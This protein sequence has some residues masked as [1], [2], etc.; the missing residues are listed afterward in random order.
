MT[1]S[2]ASRLS[3]AMYSQISSR[4][5]GHPG[6]SGNRSC[7]AGAAVLTFLPHPGKGI[8]AVNRCDSAVLH[9]IIAA[10]DHF[11]HLGQ[12]FKIS[13]Q[14]VLHEFVLRAAGI[15]CELV[16]LCLHIPWEI[17]LHTFSL[18]A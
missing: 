18:C 4:S 11:A 16:E 15:R 17:N 14:G 8:I 9:I 7:T 1:R 10:V 3:S 2:A 12:L 6:V 5:A 13:G